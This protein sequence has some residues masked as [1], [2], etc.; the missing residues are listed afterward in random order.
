[1]TLSGRPPARHRVL[2]NA[3]HANAHLLD[4]GFVPAL[5]IAVPWTIFVRT[6]PAPSA[7]DRDPNIDH[8]E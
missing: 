2:F 8:G 4:K 3:D 6:R 1:M 5:G 7:V